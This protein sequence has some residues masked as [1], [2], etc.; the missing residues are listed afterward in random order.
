MMN[1]QKNMNKQLDGNYFFKISAQEFRKLPG[2]PIAYW[3]SDSEVSSFAEKYI[4]NV[5][6]QNNNGEIVGYVNA[7][8]WTKLV[9]L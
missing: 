9:K 1:I 4:E 5:L 3:V 6:P 8:K 2:S 7:H